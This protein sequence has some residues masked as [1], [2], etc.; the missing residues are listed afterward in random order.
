ML[1]FIISFGALCLVVRI[2]S[3]IENVIL[4][5]KYVEV[6]GQVLITLLIFAIHSAEMLPDS[7]CFKKWNYTVLP[8]GSLSL[9]F[10]E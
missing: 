9:N 6:W 7:L 2:K 5:L 4:L 10:G 1:G 3:E 8:V